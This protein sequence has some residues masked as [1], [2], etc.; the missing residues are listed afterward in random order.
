M[1]YNIGL[2]KKLEKLAKKKDC[3]IVGLWIKSI[4]NHLYWCAA[5]TPDGN[6]HVIKKKWLSLVSHMHNE[7]ENCAH[8]RLRGRQ[9]NKKWICYRKCA[10][11][12]F[13]YIYNLQIPKQVKS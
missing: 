2:R 6:E 10:K 9:R 12:Q 3:E 8:R 7:H 13:A 11:T 1:L 4:C 5:S